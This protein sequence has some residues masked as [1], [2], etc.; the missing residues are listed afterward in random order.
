M[1]G[2]SRLRGTRQIRTDLQYAL[3]SVPRPN[4]VVF[5]WR[6][7]Y[8]LTLAT[9]LPAA[10]V[11]LAARLGTR[12]A[13][14]VIL[15]VTVL[16]AGAALWPAT[17]HHLVARAWCVITPHRIRSGCAQAWIHSRQG[18]I[19]IVLL[20]TREP[21][22]ERVRLWCRAGT[23]AEDFASGRHLLVAACWAQD[24][25]VKRSARYAQLVI[26]DVIRCTPSGM[27]PGRGAGSRFGLET[28]PPEIHEDRF[29]G[30][31]RSSSM[32]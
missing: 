5:A 20:T 16:A 1:I 3:G 7:R 32:L 17:R 19:P 14:Q 28:P 25:Q 22:G 29:D 24:I 26:I 18:K 13:L 8:E 11:A 2:S 12:Q 23:S 30:H 9:G 4:P 10:A 21:F 6:W 27:P 15:A 31:G